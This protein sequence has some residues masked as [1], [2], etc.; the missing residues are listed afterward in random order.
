[1]K[2]IPL[3]AVIV[4]S[5][6][7]SAATAYAQ[8]VILP[9][10]HLFPRDGYDYGPSM[11]QEGNYQHFWWC[12]YDEGHTDAIYYRWVD[13]NGPTWGPILKVLEPTPGAWDGAYT[14]DPS[15]ITGEFYNPADGDTYFFAMYY[16][17]TDDLAGGQN[18]RIGV[19][20]SHDAINWVKY[21]YPVIVPQGGP[22]SNYGA[23]QASTYSYNGAA[24]LYL[25]HFD[26]STAYGA[27]VWV[28]STSDGIN[29]SAQT[30]LSNDGAPLSQNSDFAYD[31]NSGNFYAAIALPGIPGDRE[32]YGFVF[33]RMPASDLL[34]GQGTWEV[35]AQ[36]DRNV[37]GAHLNHSPGML[38][39]R[40]G[41]LTSWLP[42]VL[43]YFAWGENESGTWDLTW[44]AIEL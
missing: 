7:T 26:E 5:F 18:N 1:M 35:L 33:A 42:V 41:N 34:N 24:G 44:A 4:A 40:Y 43:S 17:A 19:A 38:R 14:C 28:R 39:D 21:P 8:Q 13:L 20:F 37:T 6:L 2:I 32:T 9:N 36:I 11:I 22:G 16:T 31:Y 23:G 10:N 12:G 15:V 25:F 30:L 27:R 3:F 29:F